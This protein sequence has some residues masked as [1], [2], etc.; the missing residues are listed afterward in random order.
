MQITEDQS[1]SFYSISEQKISRVRQPSLQGR[2]ETDEQWLKETE[3][4]NW[5]LRRSAWRILSR[6]MILMLLLGDLVDLGR[7]VG[8]EKLSR[9]EN[10]L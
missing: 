8:S 4:L 10:V 7:L 5:F 6:L 2:V 1:W 9:E 3:L